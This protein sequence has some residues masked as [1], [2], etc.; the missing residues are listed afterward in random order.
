[1]NVPPKTSAAEILADNILKASGSA[2][3]H[4]TL[5]KN[6]DA[7]IAAAQAGID[8][9]SVDRDRLENELGLE[10]DSHS[11]TNR[12]RLGAEDMRDRLKKDNEKLSARHQVLTDALEANLKALEGR[13]PKN[14]PN[15]RAW[16]L[17]ARQNPANSQIAFEAEAALMMVEA[18]A[19]I[20]RTA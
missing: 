19:N 2:L 17:A 9:V 6:R 10:K 4:Y 11:Q 12:F 14:F 3:R 13:T 8:A 5:Q 20:K 1:M 16:A 18:L 7:I 15:V